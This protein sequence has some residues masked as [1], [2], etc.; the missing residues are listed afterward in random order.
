[1]D[2]AKYFV[3]TELRHW[4]IQM[5]CYLDICSI[6]DVLLLTKAASESQIGFV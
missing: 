2:T 6:D 3:N 1:M 4:H 5:P